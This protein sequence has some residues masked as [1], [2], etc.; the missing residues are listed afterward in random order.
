MRWPDSCQCD[1]GVSCLYNPIK[2][3][4]LLFLQYAVVLILIIILEIISGIVGYVF[5]DTT[6]DQSEDEYRERWDRAIREYDT[7]SD[8]EKAVDFLQDNVNNQ[9][10]IEFLKQ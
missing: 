4:L 9:L 10:I 7:N 2:S 1:S 8:A 5:N 3:F 6:A